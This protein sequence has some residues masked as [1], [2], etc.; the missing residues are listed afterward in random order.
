MS[1]PDLKFLGDCSK[2]DLDPLVE[3]VLK[4]KTE[5]LSKRE[6]YKN[7]P[8]NHRRYVAHLIEEIRLFGGNTIANTVRGEGVA[9]KEIATDVASKLKAKHSET[10]SVEEIEWAILGK[11]LEQSLEKMTDEER[12]KIQEELESLGLKG[13]N[14]G[15]GGAAAAIAAQIAVRGT[16]FAAYQLS[17]IVANGV[18]KAVLHRGLKLA[19]NAGLTRLVSVLAGPVGWAVTALWTAVDI[20]GPAYRVTIPCVVHVSMLRLKQQAEDL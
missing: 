5:G 17:V 2:E 1:D 19:A 11:F 4:A 10:A 14:L 15:A 9:Y 20:A 7:H 3:Y 18:A 8:G 13:M 6:V 12:A 16:G